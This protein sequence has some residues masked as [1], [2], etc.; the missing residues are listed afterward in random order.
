MWEVGCYI[1]GRFRNG[2]GGPYDATNPATERTHARVTPADEAQVRAA[3]VAARRA[4]GDWRRTSAEMRAAWLRAIADG[5]EARAAAIAPLETD[6]TGLLLTLTAQGHLP[7][8][9]QC[10]RH[11]ADEVGQPDAVF[12]LDNAYVTWVRREPLG[13][14][15]VIAPWNAPLAVAAMNTAAALALGNCVILKPSERSPLS[16]QAL[17]EV[18]NDVELPPG[19]FQVLQGGPDV[20]R[21][22][23]AAEG[24][25]G[26]CFVGGVD[27]GR[28][29]LASSAPHLK[30]L[31]LELGGKSPTLVFADCDLETA[32]DGALLSAFSSNGASCAA[33]S[34]ILVERPLY[35]DF[36]EA[37]ATR[38]ARIRVGDP[39]HAASEM[40][41]LIDHRHRDHVE[42]MVGAAIAA[43]AQAATPL[44]RPPDLPVGAYW[45]PVVLDKVEPDMRIA[46]E[47]VFGPVAAVM[48]FDDDAHAIALANDTAFG[49]HASIWSADVVRALN[50]A[51]EIEAGS[52][53]VN[54]GIVRDIRAPFG[55]RKLSGL[56]RTG[57]RWSLDAFSEPKAVSV[58][59]SPYPL[60]RLGLESSTDVVELADT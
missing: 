54:A 52:V 34:R 37:L 45:R 55:G 35:R 28:E 10:F 22:L 46:R 30:R 26:L 27:A 43:G 36:L 40:G 18:I 24:V 8:A 17:A 41:P 15:G 38:A 19:V 42:G 25:N 44:G 57:G 31:T 48:P 29:V 5:L 33:G 7:R 59:L 11:F 49:L 4:A 60:P 6:D 53:A 23:A 47:E 12:P 13:V 16:S 56:G 3:I 14:V 58:A 21:A 9:I 2:A 32:L 1:E 39:R 20:G 50:V 51:S